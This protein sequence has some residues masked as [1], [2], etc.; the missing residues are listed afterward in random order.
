MKL[1]LIGPLPP[2]LGGTTVAFRQLVHELRSREDISLEV[3]DTSPGET[4][5]PL[6]RIS[7][8]LRIWL[9]LVRAFPQCEIVSLHASSRRAVLMGAV[10]YW[11][12]RLFRKPLVVRVFGGSLDEV[13]T[14]FSGFGRYLVRTM[15]RAQV[16]LL[17]TKHLVQFFSEKFP[18]ANILWFPNSRPL[19][20]GE[21]SKKIGT[22]V[23]HRF[24]FVGHVKPSKGIRELIAAAAQL[25][26]T[27]FAVDVYGPL[28]EGMH[29]DEFLNHKYVSY[30]GMLQSEDVIPTLAAYDALVFPTYYS[31]EGY[32]GVI[33]EAY[34]AGIPVIATCWRSIPEIVEDGRSGMLVEP[35]NVASLSQAMQTFIDSVDIREVLAEGAKVKAQAFAS[36][37][38]NRQEFFRICKS[39]MAAKGLE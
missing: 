32:P 34:M 16:V 33:L 4:S 13:Y 1:L 2:P 17:Q 39:V 29:Q 5:G 31:G 14:S 9:R 10:L 24:V 8:L 6:A 22:D 18:Q 26:C 25:N 38:W 15:F 37:H 11:M 35:R 7:E 19:W 20:E 28:Q 12:C 36:T 3:I 30:R 27:N 21:P 23:D